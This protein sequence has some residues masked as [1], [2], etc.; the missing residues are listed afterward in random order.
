MREKATN[1]IV[2]H[3]LKSGQIPW[4]PGYSVYRQHFIGQ[5]LENLD[6]MSKFKGGEPLPDGYGFALDER[7]V[8]Y[9]WLFAQF[10]T[11]PERI[12]D[13]GSALNH[14]FLLDRP[15]WTGKKL[16]ILTLA[17]ETQC[18]WERGISYLF[19]DLRQIPVRD[20]YYDTVVCISTLEH[21]G[22]DNR[23]FTGAGTCEENR[24]EDFVLAVREM[25][26]TLKPSGRLLLTVPFGRYRNM[27]TQQ[28]FDGDLLEEA[29]AA[30]Q[31]AGVTRTF[32]CYTEQGWQ[33]AAVSEC[34]EKEYVDWIML[35][36]DRRS[37]QFPK[38]PD[39][40][41]AARAVACVKLEKPA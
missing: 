23:Q 34:K 16:H 17:P 10:D 33:F 15:I 35:P 3:Y 41:A 28:V 26:R 12:L 29:I 13:A 30:F 40:A 1:L 31:P 24:P 25:R 14:A 27:G 6:L 37:S 18:Y 22:F 7:C 8:E 4:S 36:A 2:K 11:Q 39:G 5:T 9:P 38:Q 32:F 20:N 21:V 19:E